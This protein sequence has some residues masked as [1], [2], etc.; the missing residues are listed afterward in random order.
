[1]DAVLAWLLD[2]LPIMGVILVVAVV[3]WW[4]SRYFKKL[5]DS[6]KKVD[7]LPCDARKND[8][9]RL[10]R[11]EAKVD[12]INEQVSDISKWIMHVDEEMIDSLAR[13][14]SPMT[15]TKIG[16]DLFRESGAEKAM[17]ENY[18]FLLSELEQKKPQTPFDVEDEALSVLLAN[19]SHPMFNEIK[20]YLYYK[21]ERI[22]FTDE[23][24]DRKEVRV[25]MFAVIRLMGL[26]LRDRYLDRHPEIK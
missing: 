2:K 1:M 23:N 22:P 20:N 17:D 13:K 26:D 14:C 24:G 25:S 7:S 9:D 8:I 5:E 6:R 16:R 11:M 18:E 12:S 21:P 3:A 19:M 10:S 4:A 15:M